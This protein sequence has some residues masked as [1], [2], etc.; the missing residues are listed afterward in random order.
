MYTDYNIPDVIKSIDISV[1]HFQHGA[2]CCKLN[3][4]LRT[5]KECSHS[6]L[7]FSNQMGEIHCYTYKCKCSDI[8]LSCSNNPVIALS[9]HQYLTI[10]WVFLYSVQITDE[11]NSAYSSKSQHLLPTKVNKDLVALLLVAFPQKL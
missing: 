8:L 7:A 9:K 1:S 2:P 3:V 11:D 5:C 6:E 10:N 4:L